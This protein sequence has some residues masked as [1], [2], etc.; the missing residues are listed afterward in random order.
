MS[1]STQV[2]FDIETLG[3]EDRS[4]ILDASV[5]VY[6]IIADAN[7]SLLEIE[8]SGKCARFKLDAAEQMKMGRIVDPETVAWWKSQ[9]AAARAIVMPDKALDISVDAF[10]LQLTNFLKKHGYNKHVGWVWQ[11]GT[12]D[13]QW[14]DSLWKDAGYPSNKK[15]LKWGKVRDI[16]TAIDLCGN[17]TKLNGYQDGFEEELKT[18]FPTF[19]PHNSIHDVLRDI[20]QLRMAGVF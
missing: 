13:I 20:M 10:Y 15:P 8:Q 18:Q 19:T 5:V 11:R 6:D 2:V 1:A 3:S 4:I 14:L 12:L 17:S 16:R 9:G 7:K